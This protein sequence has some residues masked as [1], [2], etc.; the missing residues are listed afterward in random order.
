VEAYL[1]NDQ[2][3]QPAPLR[4]LL[5]PWV[6]A[7]AG[8]LGIFGTIFSVYTFYVSKKDRELTY[9]VNPIKTIVLNSG[10]VSDLRVLHRNRELKTD[11]T[12]TQIAIWNAGKES[13][14]PEHILSEAKIVTQPAVRILEAKISKQSRDVVG[15]SKDESQFDKGVVPISWKILEYKDGAVIQLIYEGSPAINIEVV[16]TIQEQSNI[17]TTKFAGKLKTSSEQLTEFNKQNQLI[18]IIA[19]SFSVLL[20]GFSAFLFLKRNGGRS[21]N[22]FLLG[23]GV[24]LLGLGIFYLV[25]Y[26]QTPSPPFGF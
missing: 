21:F 3:V 15:F 1:N 23:E 7:I 19:L 14:R 24:V 2:A 18:A 12:A 9:Y 8:I 25:K 20:F 5:N 13:I 22:T 4:W 16:G 11:V 26:A 6:V 10:D 17:F